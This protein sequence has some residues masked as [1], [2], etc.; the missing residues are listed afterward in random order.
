M[1]KDLDLM[2]KAAKEAGK[3]LLKNFRKHYR[4]KAK[5]MH[6]F[7]TD[8][9]IASEKKIK[10]ILGK[11]GYAFLSEESGR[12]GKSD[13]LWVIDPLDG[14]TNYIIGNPIFSVSIA[15]LKNKKPLLSVVFVP[16]TKDIFYAENGNGAYMNGKRIKVSDK[17]YIKDSFLTF[18]H[19]KSEE[20]I[21]RAIELYKRLKLKGK[22]LRQFGSAS[23]ELA[24]VARGKTEALIMP[25]A[26]TWDALAGYLLVKESGGKVTD[27]KGDEWDVNKKDI[28]ATNGK[29]HNLIL[30]EIKGI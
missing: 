17:K 18:C 6:D 16:I 2:I 14:T 3:I 24:S 1:N 23:I 12:S 28:L 9:D 8:V 29:I 4:V 22:D 30:N 5:D 21:K 15:L 10:S 13:Y 20:D 27:F 19:G 26:P 11:T 7:V 25:G